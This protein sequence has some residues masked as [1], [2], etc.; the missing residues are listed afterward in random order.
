MTTHSEAKP[1]FSIS[2]S[3]EETRIYIEALKIKYGIN[4]PDMKPKKIH[5][6]IYQ[7]NMNSIMDSLEF[8][9]TTFLMNIV[10]YNLY[11]KKTTAEY[12]GRKKVLQFSINECIKILEERQNK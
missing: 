6:I 3:P 1:K 10:M 2:S 7:G 11:K 8:W 5:H 12:E 9:E 4:D